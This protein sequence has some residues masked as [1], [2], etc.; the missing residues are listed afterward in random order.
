[1]ANIGWYRDIV[2]P[3]SEMVF[4][5]RVFSLRHKRRAASSPSASLAFAVKITPLHGRPYA[6]FPFSGSVLRYVRSVVKNENDNIH[7]H[8]MRTGITNAAALP[9]FITANYKIKN[10]KKQEIHDESL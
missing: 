8:F 9:E 2:A 7:L 10:N 6:G 3:A 5:Y 4:R 1:M